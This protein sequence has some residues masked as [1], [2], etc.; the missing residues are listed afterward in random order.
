MK[1]TVGFSV[2]ACARRGTALFT[3]LALA[4]CGGG[5]SDNNRD[6]ATA[7]PASSEGTTREQA[8]AIAAP[9]AS[10]WSPLINLSLV[11]SSAANLPN[12][13]LLFWSSADRFSDGAPSGRTYTSLFDPATNTATETLVTNTGHDMFCTGTTNLPDGRIL[14]NG[15]KDAG[16]T[17]IYDPV[18]NTWSTAAAMTIAR[19]YSANTLMPDGS[20]L[21]LGGSWSGGLGGKHGEL[22]TAAG[23]WR[24]LTGV[25]VDSTQA[26]DPQGLFRADNHM[27][28]FPAPNG[29]ILQ[30]GPGAA[31]NWIDTQGNGRITPA[32]TRS[33][34][35]YS[36]SGN[37]VMYDIGKVLKVGG[38]PAYQGLNAS[39]SAYVI[40]MN[41]GVS[42]RKLAPMQ[43]ARIFSNG[44]V[45]P[46]GQVVV[47]G[48]HTLGNPFSD[49]NSVLIPELWD[50]VTE[51]FTPLPPIA[52]P[53]NYHSVAL[54]MP[55][56]RVMSGGGGL[57]GGCA[58]N[59]PNIQILTPHY[60]L[61]D[62][63]TPATRPVLNTVPTTAT[64]GTT[65]A[66]TTNSAVTSFALVR[67]G[68]T[69]HT[70][71]NDQRRIPL[72]FSSTG[73][74]AYS[75]TIPSNPHVVLPGHYMLFA[76]NA[77]GTPSVSK[78]VRISGDAAPKLT[79][80]GSQ[81]ST[82]GNTVTLNLAATTPSGTLSFAATG[83]PPGLSINPTTGAIT[84]TPTAAGQHVVTLSATNNVATTSTNVAWNV[85]V[86][87][88]AASWVRL[89]AVSETNG[90]PWTSMAEF[91]LLDRS[92]A[93][94]PRTGWQ[95]QADSQ[96]AASGNNSAAAAIDGDAATYWHTQYTG[97]TAP[98]PHR[99]TV[100]LGG[101]RTFG[102]FRYLPRPA[103]G[104][105]NGVIA[106]WNFYTSNDGTNWTLVKQGNFNDFPD[107]SAEKTEMI[108][109]PPTVLGVANRSSTVGQAVSFGISA[110]DPDGDTIGYS[111]TGLPTG[112]AIN[113]AS[114]LISGTPT[115]AGSFNVTVTANDGRSGTSSVNFGWAISASALEIQ[116]VL[117]PPQVSGNNATFNVASNGGT[118]TRYRWNFGDGTATT[119]Y[120]TATSIGHVYAAP[121]HYTVTVTAIDVNGVT[122]DLVFTQAVYATTTTSKPTQS[123]TLAIENAATP[124]VWLVNQDNDSVS[125]F[126]GNTNARVAEINVGGAPRSVAI[127]PDG[128]VWVT[129]KNDAS[130]S[131]VS[132]S[133]LAVVQTLALPRASMP[134]GIAFAPDGSAAYVALEATGNLLKL[135]ASTGATLGT[136]SVGANPRH[137]S[138]TAASN[139]VLVS[140]FISPPQ[141]GE[142]TATVQTQ[143]GGVNRG[144]EVVVVT[145]AT[146]AIERTVVLRHSDKFDGSIQGR[147]V[148]NYLH[149][150]AISP[151]GASAWVPSKQDNLQ[152]GTLRDGNALDFQNTVRAISSRIDLGSFNEDYA[153]RIDHDN[154]S[155]ASGAVYHPTGAYLFVA[156]ET[157]RQ[158]AVVNPYGR[159]EML[160]I[161][162]G[163]APGAVAVSAD[164]L[165]LYVNNFMDRTLGI[166]DLRRLVNYGESTVPVFA[167]PGAITTE[168]LATNVLIGKQFFYDAKDPRLSRD[169]YMSCASCH[170][171]GGQ[172]GRTWDLTSLGEG[173]RNTANLRGRAGAQ[174]FKH[175]S[176]NFDET[177]DFEG[178]IRTLAGGRGLMTD[179]Q[180]NTGTRSQPLGDA[181]AGVSADLDSLSAYL[182]SL[183]QFALSPLRNA[184]GSNT[185][186]AN[187]GR[188]VFVAQCVS[189][190]SGTAFTESGN[191][192][193]RNIGTLKASSGQRLGSPLTGID[194]PTLRDVWATAP[195]LH[196]GSAA[197]LGDAVR[198]HTGLTLTTTQVNDVVAYVSQIGREETASPAPT[199]VLAGLTVADTA[200][201]ADWS[202]QSNLQV[203]NLQFGDR[204]FTFTTVPS[205]VAGSAWIRAA[206]DSK[207]FAGNPTVSFTINRSADVY[208]AIDDRIG[209]PFGWMTT[210]WVSTGIKLVNN[211][212][213]P[214]PLTLYRKNFAAGTVSLGGAA[215]GNNMY[216]V[217]VK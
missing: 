105:L 211:E 144:G 191:A 47:I 31:M 80:P 106:G 89:E 120:S 142:A 117:A 103:A 62:N 179:A 64:H 159:F 21:T 195:Y 23:G 123:S 139:R 153:A 37:A 20:V 156:L 56:G 151:D 138:V 111:A 17:S 81:N 11:P 109:R 77:A 19:G 50:P 61:N 216:S 162:T 33:D 215:T 69:T 199:L 75:L 102:G 193:L 51:T 157:S 30:A 148:P 57:C 73:T 6:D 97:T 171:D 129:N 114:G 74:N 96:E 113:T 59:H 78:N 145:A 175:W 197:T 39:N 29:Q 176:A 16:K 169:A 13:K 65:M 26:P 66:V 38:A 183:N 190:H 60:L 2:H 24:R 10:T 88:I 141:P 41:A 196:D 172:D 160:R 110:G 213:T 43:Y 203:G 68:S 101:P 52:T 63:G 134:F 149:A 100:N 3:A 98:M 184:D 182:A 34:D 210:G 112:L 22:W 48:G 107:R 94:I 189:C 150:A 1:T 49:N 95:V 158:V 126:N 208:V 87:A 12:G 8:M 165:K 124:R 45:L 9:G 155:L 168:R 104:G 122:R 27:W 194:T 214:R 188:T 5:G 185:A 83:L 14:A 140:R 116:P 167:S 54:L 133:T 152:R 164:G 132:P 198:A 15:G 32:G 186:A 181:K 135:N 70:I 180:F 44:V 99:Y 177:Q 40:D 46:N 84:G 79:N 206:N 58:T 128:R 217:I 90:Q 146:M 127:A 91:N 170:N 205:Q 187:A 131:I 119:A 166:Y 82:T 86:P 192:T 174:G 53:R 76:M 136:V 147:G 36:Q 125:V 143:V 4:A 130:I 55:D 178:Q 161:D 173:L 115:A 92:G 71:N 7:P 201:A 207:G 85:V 118:G 204:T 108:N 93:T 18:T 202:I 137:V 163:R 72:Q 67:L 25:P 35:A 209:A 121:G 212:A 200:N 154:S 28:L 42:V